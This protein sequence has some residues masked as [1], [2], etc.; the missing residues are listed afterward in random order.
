MRI[1]K[2]YLFIKFGIFDGDKKMQDSAKTVTD[3]DY[4]F[5][6][7]TFDFLTQFISEK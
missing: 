2:N 6:I 4:R 7:I 1:Q 3:A 5:C